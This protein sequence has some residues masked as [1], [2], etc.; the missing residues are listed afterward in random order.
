MKK[1]VLLQ[2]IALL[3]ACNP[4]SDSTPKSDTSKS[5]ISK[6]S[7][8]EPKGEK[9]PFQEDDIVAEI[10]KAFADINQNTAS[11]KVESKEIMDESTEG[12]ELKAYYQDEDLKKVVASYFG[13]MGKTVEE[14][15]FSEENAFFIFTQQYSYDKPITVEGSAVKQIEENRY[16]LHKNKL[17]RWIG[18]N[19]EKV[20]NSSF[21][22]KEPEVLQKIKDLKKKLGSENVDMKALFSLSPLSIFD[23]TTEGLSLSEKNDLLKKGA[24]DSW[25]IADED[26]T[27][28]TL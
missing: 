3:F 6:E 7:T 9:E 8:L 20:A 21:S 2:L 15:Y 22:Q 5:D 16:Y 26:K 14:Y 1:V 17:M 28:L 4:S 18:S 27:K 11:Y 24:S 19:K 13:E 10:K 25:E 12:G 23:E